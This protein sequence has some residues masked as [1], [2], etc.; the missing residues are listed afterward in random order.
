MLEIIDA[1]DWYEEQREGL[2][3]EFLEELDSF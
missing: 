3:A 1:F 2:D